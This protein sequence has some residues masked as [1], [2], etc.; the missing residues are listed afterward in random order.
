MRLNSITGYHNWTNSFSIDRDLSPAQIQFGNNT[1]DHWFWSQELR[2][3][4]DFGKN[5]HTTL[6]GYYSDEKTTYYTLQDIRY[7]GFGP[8]VPGFVCDRTGLPTPGCPI[9]PLQFLGNDPVKT[10]SKAGFGTA[11]W[12]LTDRPCPS[13]AGCATRRTR[14]STRS[15]ATTSTGSRINPFLDPVGAANGIGYNGPNGV[16][17][18]GHT[19]TFSG[20]RTD[21][22]VSLD[23]RFTPAIMAYGSIGTGYKAGGVGPRPFNTAQ[24]IG[25]GPEN[26]H[27]V[28]ARPEDRLVRPHACAFNT[29]IFYNDFKDA[30]LVLTS[31]PQYG[32]RA[33]LCAAPERRQRRRQRRGSSRSVRH[34]DRRPAVR[35]VRFVPELGLEV[36]EPAGGGCRRDWLLERS[37]GDRRAVRD[38]DRIHQGA[39]CTP[40]SSTR[41]LGSAT[42]RP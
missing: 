32:G 36:R 16:A 37:G 13:P 14:R 19:A 3:N 35:P 39:G 30:Q 22:H 40:A 15:I 21:W 17:L 6:G 10:T 38:P 11:I 27:R 12:D 42:G 33:S 26:A 28:R 29:A 2:L 34:A 8:T 18:S 31:C 4:I 24:A 25:F 5:V 1:L 9:Y 23:Y 7:V 41:S 20:S